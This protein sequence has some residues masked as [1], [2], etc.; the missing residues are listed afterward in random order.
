MSLW[1]L[2]MAFLF[3]YISTRRTDRDLPDPRRTDISRISSEAIKWKMVTA[4]ETSMDRSDPVDQLH[5]NLYR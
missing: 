2:W 3:F 5:D 1:A 4:A